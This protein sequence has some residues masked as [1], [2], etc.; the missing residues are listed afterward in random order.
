MRWCWWRSF[1]SGVGLPH[2]AFI[3]PTHLQRANRALTQVTVELPNHQ[4][5]WGMVKKGING[6]AN[7][8][9]LYTIVKNDEG[10]EVKIQRCYLR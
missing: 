2:R 9:S 8:D 5:F 4:P 1:A 10:D 6:G 3:G 7:M